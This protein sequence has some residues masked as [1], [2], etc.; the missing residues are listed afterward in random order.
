MSAL[1]RTTA[2]ILL[3]WTGSFMLGCAGYEGTVREMRSALLDGDKQRALA[4]SAKTLDVD[5]PNAFPDELDGDNSLLLL[6]RAMVKQGLDDYASSAADFGVAD[7]HL[8]LLDLQN[9]TMGSI[10]KYI[11]SDDST[12][13]RAPAYEK[14]LVNTFNMVNYLTLGNFEGARVEARRLRVMQKYLKGE[15]SDQAALLD[16]GS[17]LAGF[18]FE[19]SGQYDQA[20]SFYADALLNHPYRS[21]IEP[22]RRIASCTGGRDETIEGFIAKNG[23]PFPKCIPPT[24][25]KGTL[26][27]VAGVG[28]A[29]YKVAKRIPIGAALVIAGHLIG[30]EHEPE[31]QRL[32]ARGL[33][34]WVNF[35]VMERSPLRFNS[36]QAV[37]DGQSVETE[38]GSHIADKVIA[39]WDS[40]KGKLMA[41]AIIRMVTR[42]IAGL[43]TEKA[44]AKATDS[45]IGGLL[46]GLAV[47]GTMT[48]F[49][50]PDTRSWVTLPQAVY[51]AR[52]E[53]PPGTHRISLVYRGDGGAVQDVVREVDVKAGGFYVVSASSMR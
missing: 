38:L 44:V 53:L 37:V 4:L 45:A 23:G 33:L 48:A 36:I 18:A 7:K 14:L 34:T 39:A 30:A 28:L 51:F 42:L 3:L 10:G 16:L 21:L 2:G 31:M 6:E 9:D 1:I 13:Y 20:L 27:V 52:V 15:E 11:F 17:Y 46:A 29:P 26:L 5:D 19:A 32:M 40:I 8:E 49:D 25:E 22:I 35:P 24:Q 50:T 43:A 12:K 47:Q 41:A